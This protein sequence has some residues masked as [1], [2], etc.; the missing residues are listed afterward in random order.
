MKQQQRILAIINPISGTGG[1]NSMPQLIHSQLNHELYD[2]DIVFTEYAGHATSLTKK[3]VNEGVDIVM[4][5]GGD[6]TVNEVARVLCDTSTA[7][8]IVPCGSGNGLARHLHIPLNSTKAIEMLNQGCNIERVDY[9]T[10]NERSFFCTCGL[11]FDAQVSY[12][13]AN[14]DTRGL[15]TYVKT[16]INEYFHYR[17]QHYRICIDGETLDEKAFVIACC[18]AAQ[19]GNNAI[20]A[21][22]AS[23]RDGMID[24]TV[25]HSFNF[26]EAALLG[27]RLFTSSIDQDRHVSIYRGSEIVIE[28]DE[29][30]VM[31]IDGDPVMMPKLLYIKCMPQGLHVVVPKLVQPI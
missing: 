22:R 29:P 13:F 5:V 14:E 17:A 31:H 18:N 23:M 12:K 4:A 24:I 3:A 28:R 16:T 26:A 21:P 20:I 15:V 2:V 1:K 9:C 6:G 27:V 7:L 8:A 10:V 30:D 25:I 11:G 19:Y